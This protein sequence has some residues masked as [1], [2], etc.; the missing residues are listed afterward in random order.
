LACRKLRA[1][2]RRAGGSL[3]RS[4]I[5]SD[6]P[7]HLWRP[8]LQLVEIEQ[9]CKPWKNDLSS[10]LSITSSSPE[11]KPIFSLRFRPIA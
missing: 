11:L 10:R 8:Y 2:R 4:N 3:L 6:D 1:V 7:G 9:A 5:S